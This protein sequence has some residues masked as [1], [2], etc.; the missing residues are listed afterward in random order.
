[1]RKRR[2]DDR[3]Q[4]KSREASASK[5][6]RFVQPPQDGDKSIRHTFGDVVGAHRSQLATGCSHRGGRAARAKISS[7][8]FNVASMIP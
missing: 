2:D 1:L 5:V 8:Q 3:G 6:A 7:T 4:A